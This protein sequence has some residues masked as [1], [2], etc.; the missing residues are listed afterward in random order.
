[1]IKTVKIGVTSQSKF[2]EIIEAFI[3][4]LAVLNKNKKIVDCLLNIFFEDCLALWEFKKV[5]EYES[6]YNKNILQTI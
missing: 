2:G 4:C 5:F 6:D 1:M 3:F